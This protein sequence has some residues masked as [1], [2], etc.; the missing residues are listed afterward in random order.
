MALVCC[1]RFGGILC[2]RLQGRYDYG[3]IY[4]GYKGRRS[5][6]PAGGGEGTCLRVG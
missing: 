1:R 2:L 3:K 6:G 4:L 5:P